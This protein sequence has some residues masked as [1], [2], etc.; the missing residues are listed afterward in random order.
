MLHFSHHAAQEAVWDPPLRRFAET[1]YRR[2]I[3]SAVASE[4][5]SRLMLRLNS[6]RRNGVPR[7]LGCSGFADVCFGKSRPDGSAR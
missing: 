4:G 5:G 7:K 1:A 2:R 6:W 3:T